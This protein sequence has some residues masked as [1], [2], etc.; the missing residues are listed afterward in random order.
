MRKPWEAAPQTLELDGLTWVELHRASDLSGM[1][2][3]RIHE[4]IERNALRAREEGGFLY[5]SKPTVARLKGEARTTKRQKPKLS[6]SYKREL[7]TRAPHDGP[8]AA[9]EVQDVLPMSSGRAGKG[10]I[11]GNSGD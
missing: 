7:T 3:R 2:I 10:W 8:H 9:R 1:G 4:K 11:G 6:Y 5:V